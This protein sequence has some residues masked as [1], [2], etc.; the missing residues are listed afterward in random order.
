MINKVASFELTPTS[1][2]YVAPFTSGTTYL[3]VV[4]A[5]GSATGSLS[6]YHTCDTS[7][8]ATSAVSLTNKYS[9]YSYYNTNAPTSL[10]S[11][12]IN[13]STVANNSYCYYVNLP[14]TRNL[15]FVGAAAT[16]AVTVDVYC[17]GSING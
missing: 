16:G 13:L 3:F 11:G 10:L 2:Q 5:N 15:L 8:D 4:T 7:A 17:D 9:S 6:M 12:S 1:T 14:V